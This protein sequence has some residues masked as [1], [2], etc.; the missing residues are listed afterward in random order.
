MLQPRIAVLMATHNGERFL[1]EQLDSI[2]AQQQVSVTLI[3]SD[4]DSK[5]STLEIIERFS[6]DFPVQVLPSQR[7]G[8]AQANFYRLI[9]D[10]PLEGFDAIAFADQDDIWSI[11]RL[12]KTVAALEHADAVSSNV[13]AVFSTRRVLVE[14]NQP[15]RRFDFVCE[16]AGPGSTYLLTREAFEFVQQVVRGDQRVNDTAAHDW[17]VYAI[18]RAAGLRW[19][20]LPDSLVEYRQHDRNATGANL[21]PRQ[22]IA[23]ARAL[24]NGWH[25]MQSLRVARIALDVATKELQPELRGLVQLF[26]QTTP[27]ARLQLAARVPQL[28]RRRRDQLALRTAILSG[29]W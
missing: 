7:F 3:V 20:I 16:S 9:R 18:C 22:A 26:E 13:T 24:R 15:Q 23:R 2:R 14:K 5:D 19:V 27:S 8:S 6:A 21:G 28:R 17:T 10:A 1:Q 11:D 29:N 4:D 12:A 25:R